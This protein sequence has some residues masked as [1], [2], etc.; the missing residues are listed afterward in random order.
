MEETVTERGGGTGAPGGPLRA[1][2]SPVE[3]VGV[4]LHQA[5]RILVL[6]SRSRPTSARVAGLRPRPRFTITFHLDRDADFPTCR[7]RLTEQ[8][9]HG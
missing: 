2:R 9:L 3:Q 7:H 6:R 8:W 5:A 1:T 4:G